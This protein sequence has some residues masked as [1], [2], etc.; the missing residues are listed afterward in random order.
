MM[1]HTHSELMMVMDDFAYDYISNLNPD[2]F[3][4]HRRTNTLSRIYI[5]YPGSIDANIHN[6]F[7][8]DHMRLLSFCISIVSSLGE[9]SHLQVF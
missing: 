3:H 4:P 9:Q 7:P 8:N 2:V 1:W 5:I 6:P